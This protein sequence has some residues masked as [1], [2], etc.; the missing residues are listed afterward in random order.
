VSVLS[1]KKIV[2]VVVAVARALKVAVEGVVT[3]AESDC[4]V[5]GIVVTG[6]FRAADCSSLSSWIVL[7]T[8]AWLSLLSADDTTVV[9]ELMSL[10]RCVVVSGCS[11]S[12]VRLNG[13]L[14]V[15]TV[16][17][18]DRAGDR[19]LSEDR[20]VVVSGGSWSVVRSNGL[21]SVLTVPIIDRA[22]D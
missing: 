2:L 6:F 8:S 11:W 1:Q 22:G 5:G 19:L 14:S 12:V 21:L 20:C 13:L 17:M 3:D 16:P 4:A 15:L 10:I 9:S 18:I 7:S